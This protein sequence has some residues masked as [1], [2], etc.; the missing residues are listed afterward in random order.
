[1]TQHA[2]ITGG[3][4]AWVGSGK[5]TTPHNEAVKLKVAHLV[6]YAF[7]RRSSPVPFGDACTEGKLWFWVADDATG[8]FHLV[9][10]RT[11]G[12]PDWS[13]LIWD[14]MPG[15]TGASMPTATLVNPRKGDIVEFDV[16]A[17][18]NTIANG[19]GQV[20]NYGWRI[21]SDNATPL[22]LQGQGAAK[23]PQLYA[24][25]TRKP[26]TPTDLSPSG[27]TSL[28]KPIVKAHADDTTAEEDVSQVR[29]QI[30][31]PA[32]GVSPDGTAPDWDSGLED[33]QALELDLST[34]T[35]PTFPGLVLGAAT[36]QRCMWVNASGASSSWSDWYPITRKDKVTHAVGNPTGGVV[37]DLT[38]ILLA[39]ASAA[40]DSWRIRV[41]DPTDPSNVLASSKVHPATG[42][43]FSWEVPKNVLVDGESYQAQFDSWDDETRAASAGDPR[44]T[45]TV[46][47][48]TVDDVP[49]VPTPTLV[50]VTN[51]ADYPAVDLAVAISDPPDTFTFRR[52]DE[53]TD[54]KVDAADIYDAT[55][56]H[57]VFRQAAAV[58]LSPHDF[59]VRAVFDGQQSVW[60]NTLTA[61]V[62]PE[63]LWLV[64]I[65]HGLSV[66][67][68][69]DGIEDWTVEDQIG[70]FDVQGRSQ[71]V[72]IRS[73]L[74]ALG[75]SFM[76]LL[77]ATET[78]SLKSLRAD[79]RAMRKLNEPVRLIA[80]DY[81][82]DV[83][84]WNVTDAPHPLSF[85]GALKRRVGFRFAESDS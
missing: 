59:Q 75:G 82:E 80:A 47:N 61:T 37:H 63:G 58:P 73:S 54:V 39:T 24:G 20:K 42:T 43:T 4:E 5:P 85:K 50:S 29:W 10:R 79:L 15:V 27:T 70:I 78:R 12:G 23:P 28:A 69:G 18:L 60:S 74:G 52:D 71:K 44:H 21:E 25:W 1:M 38:P 14:N 34:T 11:A 13:N 55:S 66:P 53:V 22:W 35:S 19:Y 64:S 26:A 49:G 77:M 30:D 72:F 45:R 51:V 9:A 62:E 76:G 33:A 2:T 8:T 32:A 65:K 67:L 6:N 83:R 31:T 46:V 17:H 41:V 16:Q 7:V 40:I 81:S 48:F 36:W 3:H 84:I 57:Y 56:G 68:S